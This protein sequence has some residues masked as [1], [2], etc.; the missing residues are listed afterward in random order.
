MNAPHNFTVGVTGH[1]PNRLAVGEATVTARLVHVLRAI[2]IGCGGHRRVAVSSL[3]EG[4][5]RLFAEVA[6]RL[7][8]QL[9]VLLPFLSADYETTFSDATTTPVYRALL[10]RAKTIRELPGSLT[11]SKAAYEAVGRATVAASDVLVAI[12]DGKPAAGR[13]GTPEIIENGLICGRPVIWINAGRDRHPLL[14]QLP[15]A[16]GV[17]RVEI[18]RLARRAMPV[19]IVELSQ[20]ASRTAGAREHKGR[21]Y[22]TGG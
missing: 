4:S 1:R 13:G 14:L 17:R 5:D 7:G 22:Q 10:G 12:W 19:T 18:D 6:L 3:A 2:R 15:S 20:L 8:Y 9:D 11:D 16:H 21:Y